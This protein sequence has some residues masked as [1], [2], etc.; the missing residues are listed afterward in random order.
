MQLVLRNVAAFVRL[1]VVLGLMGAL[2]LS[3]GEAQAARTAMDPLNRVH[4]GLSMADAFSSTGVTAGMDSRLTR[5]VYLDAGLFLSLDE[6]TAQAEVDPLVDDPKG[7]FELR[8]G[9]Y[10]A[11]GIRVPHRFGEG[12]NWDLIG[13]GGFCVA[14]AADASQPLDEGGYRNIS[15]PGLLLGADLLLQYKKAGLRLA[16][17]AIGFH[18]Y[19]AT[20]RKETNVVRPQ[21]AVE[22]VWQ[23]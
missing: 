7:F 3:S 5:F 14:W 12:F 4:G 9:V 13:R 21:F 8:H 17:K 10:V 1:F 15:E 20:A 6:P 19:S 22:G 16:G 11:P 2:T 23:F 18:T